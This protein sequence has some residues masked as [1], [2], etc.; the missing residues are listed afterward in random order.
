VSRVALQDEISTIHASSGKTIVFVTHDMDEAL[1]LATAMA[2]MKEGR[3]IQTGTPDSILLAPADDFVRDFL[4]GEALQLRLL[5]LVPVPKLMKTGKTRAAVTIA[6]GAS[7][8]S[9]L[10]L[11][12]AH[13]C[14]SL[15]VEDESGARLGEIRLKDTIP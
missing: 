8:K 6:A 15:G 2:V 7:L 10:N 13:R 1:R 9:A 3:L 12:L 5:D 4:G 11:M 14:S